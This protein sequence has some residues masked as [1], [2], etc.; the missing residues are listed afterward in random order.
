MIN[1]G[2]LPEEDVKL[3]QKVIEFLKERTKVKSTKR[4][5]IEAEEIVFVAHPSDV[6]GELTRK[7]IYDYL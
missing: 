4:E 2:D 1:L 7:E 3:V 6:I 5:K